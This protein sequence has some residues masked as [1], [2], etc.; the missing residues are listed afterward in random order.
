MGSRCFP[1]IPF[2]IHI[3]RRCFTETARKIGT[4]WYPELDPYLKLGPNFIVRLE[5]TKKASK[6]PNNNNNKNFRGDQDG[7]V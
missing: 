5:V 1:G 7:R 3:L 6:Q 4:A 2:L